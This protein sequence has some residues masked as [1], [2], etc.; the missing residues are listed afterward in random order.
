MEPLTIEQALNRLGLVRGRDTTYHTYLY[1]ATDGK[2]TAIEKP[3]VYSR[4]IDEVES[5]GYVRV[6]EPD[7]SRAARTLGSI[8]SKRK[9]ASSAANGRKGGRPRKINTES[10]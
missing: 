9:A 5:F 1:W 6:F 3:D 2:L 10:F 8:R 7:A 4:P